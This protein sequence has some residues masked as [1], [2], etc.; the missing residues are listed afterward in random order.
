[1]AFVA[2]LLSLLIAGI[3][4]VGVLAPNVLLAAVT[5]MRSPFGLYFAAALRVVLGVA[6]FFAAPRSRAPRVFRVLGALTVVAGLLLPF[7]GF[8]RF[9]AMLGWWT[10]Q[11]AALT[12]IWAVVA[13]MVGLLIAYG[14]IPKEAR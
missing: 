5:Q 11:G 4:A 9:D 12:R 6:L 1:M 3:G 7:V 13:F 2:F 10:A 14:V 8:E